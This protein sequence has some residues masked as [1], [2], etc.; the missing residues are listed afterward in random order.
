MQPRPAWLWRAGRAL[1]RSSLRLTRDGKV[2]D[3]EMMPD[4][5]LDLRWSAIRDQ[6]AA[7]RESADAYRD[8]ELSRLFHECGW[9]QERIA[10]RMR[11]AQPWVS[12]RLI[13]GAFLSFMP[14]GIKT[15]F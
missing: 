14:A 5:E 11:Q 4:Q 13:F 15:D 7:R 1:Y 8:Q 9:T 2:G 3:L 6:L 12:R 10:E